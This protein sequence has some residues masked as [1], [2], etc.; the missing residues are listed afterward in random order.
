M[1]NSTKKSKYIKFLKIILFIIIVVASLNVIYRKYEEKTL[2][3]EIEAVITKDFSKDQLNTS[4]KTNLNYAK[5]EK[6]IKNYLTDYS[7]STKKIL[8][9]IN[10]DK[11]KTILSSS[12]YSSD[13][14]NFLSTTSYLTELKQNINNEI[15]SLE[16]LTQTKTIMS[17]I[18]RDNLNKYYEKLYKQ[19][20]IKQYYKDTIQTN[21]N[22]IKNSTDNI[23]L[24]IDQEQQVINFLTNCKTW[25]IKDGKLIFNKEDDLITY[26]NLIKE[27]K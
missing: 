26:N 6:E 24:L 25:I 23:I 13:G 27:I 8:T 15:T 14:P 21:Y 11:L 16:E 9:L 12:N 5:V 19:L 18:K 1:K 17:Y 4:I 20:L 3:K 10:D 7:T 2:K 22:K